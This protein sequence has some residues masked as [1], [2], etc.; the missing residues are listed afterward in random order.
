M[1]RKGA[2]F[3]EDQVVLLESQN[4]GSEEGGGGGGRRGP[5]W[6]ENAFCII[7][8]PTTS[9]PH[10]TPYKINFC[11]LGSPTPAGSGSISPVSYNNCGTAEPTLPDR[12]TDGLIDGWTDGWMDGRMFG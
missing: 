7:H 1:T 11:P 6:G 9:H 4:K 3:I 2:A 8:T 10:P 12:W 5:W